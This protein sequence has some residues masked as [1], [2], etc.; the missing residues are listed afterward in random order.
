MPRSSMT[1]LIPRYTSDAVLT[2]S[3][4]DLILHSF[5]PTSGSSTYD[6]SG[7]LCNQIPVYLAFYW[8][9]P[10]YLSPHKFHIAYQTSFLPYIMIIVYKTELHSRLR[11]FFLT[12]TSSSCPNSIWHVRRDAIFFSA[13]EK[14]PLVIPFSHCRI[15]RSCQGSPC[16]SSHRPAFVLFHCRWLRAS[17]P[18]KLPLQFDRR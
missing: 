11:I 13:W 6:I 18:M 12:I 1:C 16:R 9:C 15:L 5:C 7:I 8:S 14:A 17:L 10:L 2:D 3:S 4:T